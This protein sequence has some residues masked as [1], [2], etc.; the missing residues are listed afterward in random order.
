MEGM[1][2]LLSRGLTVGKDTKGEQEIGTL[3]NNRR[4]PGGQPALSP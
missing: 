4:R 1:Q 3:I 2:V